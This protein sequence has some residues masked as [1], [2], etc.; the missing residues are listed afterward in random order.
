MARFSLTIDHW[1]T[2]RFDEGQYFKKIKAMAAKEKGTARVSREQSPW[3]TYCTNVILS[4]ISQ[5]RV[6]R[7]VAV[8]FMS[9][10]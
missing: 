9:A 1:K 7:V 10:E 3:L 4:R 5:F 8:Q 6:R 2:A